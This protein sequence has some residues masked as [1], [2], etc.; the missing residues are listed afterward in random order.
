MEKR[1][2]YE[3]LEV[4]KNATSDEIKKAYRKMAIKY[5]PDKNPDDKDAEEKFKEAAE[6]YEVLSNPDKRSRYDQFGHAGLNGQQGFS[7]MDDIF[8]HFGDIFSDLFG[9][10]GGGFSFSSGFGGGGRQAQRHVNRGS[11]LRL[12]VKLNLSEINEGVKKKV[13]V[14]KFVPCQH[15]GGSGAKDNS[16]ET[17]PTC[18][19]RGQTVK[20]QNS[21][22]GQMQ[23]VTTCPNCGGEGKIIKN[24]CPECQGNGIVKSEEIIELNIPAGVAEG[25]QLSVRGKGNAGARNG[26][27]GDLIILIEEE[28]DKN[29]ERDGND[30]IYNLFISFPQAALGATVEVPVID[31]TTEVKIPAG[32]QSGEVIK[33]R[34]KGLP[35]LN[36]YG[37]GDLLVNV[38]VWTPQHLNKEEEKIMK[39]LLDSENMNPNSDNDKGPFKRFKKFFS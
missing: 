27:A 11:N 1:D 12:R 30:L 37:R 34:N 8:S 28:K 3:V 29:L 26:I 10:G 36:G 7:G 13:K 5:H 17:C 24:K 14:N 38:N 20:I 15:C 32:T 39:S 33:L 9:G 16:F 22:F 21:I 4:P 19:G 31:G 18:N 2:Y 35:E 23:T 25:M 6:A